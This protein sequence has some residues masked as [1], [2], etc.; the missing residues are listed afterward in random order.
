MLHLMGTFLTLLFVI[1]ATHVTGHPAEAFILA[2]ALASTLTLI[3]AI[4]CVIRLLPLEHALQPGIFLRERLT[5]SLNLSWLQFALD[6]IIWQRSE[7][8]LLAYW[9]DPA[10]IGFY[11]LSASISTRIIGIAPALFARWLFPLLLR[12]LPEHRYLN[13]YDAFVKTSCYIIFLAVPI[14]ATVILLCPGA[15]VYTLGTTYLPIVRP[16]RILLIAAVFGSIATVSLTHLANSERARQRSAQQAQSWLNIG[17]AILKIL[18]AIPFIWRW[19]LTG[20]A[21]A[22]ALAQIASALASILLCK[23]LLRHHEQ[24]DSPHIVQDNA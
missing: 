20:A 14:C 8:L 23:K 10:Q 1:I 9:R 18:L 16:L 6:A 2:F 15:I 4:I 24:S 22:S 7:L 21:C 12:Y 3:L 13:P 5:H 19:G 11:A 17:I